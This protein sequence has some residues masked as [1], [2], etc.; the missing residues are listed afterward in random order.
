[1]ILSSFGKSFIMKVLS[2]KNMIDNCTDKSL[3][4]KRE[5]SSFYYSRL[6]KKLDENWFEG[7]IGGKVGMFPTDYVEVVI[8]LP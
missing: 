2:L 4:R 7:E 8:P 6:K 3:C 1:M 5:K